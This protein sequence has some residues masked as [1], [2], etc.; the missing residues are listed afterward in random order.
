MQPIKSV[1]RRLSPPVLILIGVVA[2]IGVALAVR[3]VNRTASNAPIAEVKVSLSVLARDHRDGPLTYP[4]QPP[5]GGV[6]NGAWINCGIYKQQVAAE[7][8]VHSLEHGAVW[9][10]YNPNLIEAEIIT[11]REAVRD[12]PYTLLA[13]ARYGALSA[14][15]VAVAWGTRLN[16]P[17]ASDPRLVRFIARYAN[18]PQSPEPGAACTGGIGTPN[19]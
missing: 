19:G 3:A 14:P 15:V 5:V 8:A 16:L 7:S 13:P 9:I 4:E 6:H 11:L 1:P 2:L 17:S 10:S 18:G 12:H